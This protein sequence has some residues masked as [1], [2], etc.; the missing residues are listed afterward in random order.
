MIP[1][2]EYA[3]LPEAMNEGVELFKSATG[4]EITF[5]VKGLPYEVSEE[6]KLMIYRIFQECLSNVIKHSKATNAK[7]ELVFEEPHLFLSIQDDGKGFHPTA[8]KKGVGLRNIKS[9]AE[10]IEGK[11]DI[12]SEPGAG[13]LINLKV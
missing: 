10:L 12:T 11:L 2:L 7:I 3:S 1:R 6:K 8:T 9:R 13:T 5:D 4:M